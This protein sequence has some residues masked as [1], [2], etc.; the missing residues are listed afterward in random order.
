MRGSSPKSTS[1]DRGTPPEQRYLILG[2]FAAGTMAEICL[3]RRLLR[4]GEL[5]E[6]ALKRL[7]ASLQT[8]QQFMT[9]FFDEALI[10]SRLVHPNIV[11]IYELF[12]MDA[13]QRSL[14]IAMEL[15][16]GV[17]LMELHSRLLAQRIRM[18]I[19]I[20]FTIALGALDA[21][22]YAHS[23]RGPDGRAAPVIH[24]DVAPQNILV[25]WDGGVKLVDFGV[26]KAEGRMQQR[27]RA[28]GLKGKLGYMSPEQLAGLPID[29][30]SDLFALGE[31][32]F[33]LIYDVH[34]FQAERDADFIQAIVRGHAARV[35][36][37]DAHVPPEV[38]LIL[39]QMLELQPERR[40]S[41]ARELQQAILQAGKPASK[42]MLGRF[43]SQIF[44]DRVS[45]EVRARD[46]RNDAL[47]V[48]SMRVGARIDPALWRPEHDETETTG[49]HDT[50]ILT[51]PSPLP[52][53]QT[54]IDRSTLLPGERIEEYALLRKITRGESGDLY[55]AQR[56]GRLEFRKRVVLKLF[57]ESL[58]R[59]RGFAE[60][61]IAEARRTSALAH[62]NI[63]Q[64]LDVGANP[65]F[66][67]MEQVEGWDL[68]RVLDACKIFQA[69]IPIGVVCRIVA[70]VCAAL[71]FAHGEGLHTVHGS[72]RPS[73]VVL[74]R[75]GT[76]K[77]LFGVSHSRAD[78]TADEA[79]DLHAARG[80]LQVLGAES[81]VHGSSSARALRMDL[82]SF[83][84]RANERSSALALSSWVCNLFVR[85]NPEEEVT[86]A[87]RTAET[88]EDDEETALGMKAQ[89]PKR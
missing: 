43:V 88:L 62:P 8:D 35:P 59:E 74:S 41:D 19:P 66:V 3:A 1:V 12:E 55:L 5:Q 17:N 67:V 48:E 15:V 10:A 40:W 46:Q 13:P 57:H 68:S 22:S 71:D 31:V 2:T 42:E 11:E 54:I 7:L 81:A 47:L 25:S 16:R 86:S 45:L 34:P 73:K 29:G 9:M 58:V 51:P 28:G 64:M 14:F 36:A 33:Q 39:L 78:D 80:L 37:G 84:L 72:L 75:H 26:A 69:Q 70:D 18:P 4:G 21:L 50:Q 24:R 79:R 23:F 60:T 27:T 65:L 61:V 52:R 82:E 6:V 20:A 53:E 83:L 77:V 85:R 89:K 32:L 38:A 44:V 30:R 76:V 56:D 49:K 87:G 63:V